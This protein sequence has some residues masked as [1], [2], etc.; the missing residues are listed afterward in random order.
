MRL[1]SILKFNG[2]LNELD[3]TSIKWRVVGHKMAFYI[4]IAFPICSSV[5]LWSAGLNEFWNIFGN[6]LLNFCFLLLFILG[7]RYF[8]SEMSNSFR[9]RLFRIDKTG[10]LSEIIEGFHFAP[11]FVSGIAGGIIL[12]ITNII[13]FRGV[14]DSNT[15]PPF[16]FMYLLGV[17]SFFLGLTALVGFQ[18]YINQVQEPE[19]WY[20]DMLYQEALSI[21]WPYT[22]IFLTIFFVTG[23]TTW[24]FI[25]VKIPDE[26]L[27]ALT[28]T[29]EISIFIMDTKR[30]Y[31]I[32][33]LGAIGF[34]TLIF[35]PRW[36][37]SLLR[38]K[39]YYYKLGKAKTR[40]NQGA[41][42]NFQGAG[43]HLKY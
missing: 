6:F 23:F 1:P 18:D 38:A 2:I 28:G 31:A 10:R 42:S 36:Y 8:W 32:V 39:M 41:G 19:E 25:R 27:F 43:T 40:Q 34:I 12:F 29:Y 35:L 15:F 11:K 33:S 16:Y 37:L 9:K 17:L 22:F 3:D 21:I 7:V 13:Y 4:A 14:I 20:I 30:I 5:I 26:I 24:T